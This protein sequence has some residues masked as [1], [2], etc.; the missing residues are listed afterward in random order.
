MLNRSFQHSRDMP[1]A[2]FIFWEHSFYSKEKKN[3]QMTIQKKQ[4]TSFQL[5]CFYAKPIC[6]NGFGKH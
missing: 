6:L 3:K 4:K 5:L 1:F 2:H